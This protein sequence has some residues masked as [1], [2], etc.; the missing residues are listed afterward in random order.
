MVPKV[1][2]LF[3]VFASFGWEKESCLVLELPIIEELQNHNSVKVSR[4]AR[5]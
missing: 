2:V 5:G 4:D 1:L 3:A